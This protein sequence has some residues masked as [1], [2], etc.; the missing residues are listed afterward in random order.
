MQL[1][2]LQH[3]WNFHRHELVGKIIWEVEWLTLHVFASKYLLF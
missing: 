3:N 2:P 1:F